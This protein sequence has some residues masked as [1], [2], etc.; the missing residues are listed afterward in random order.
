MPSSILLAIFLPSRP[1]FSNS[2]G[3]DEVRPLVTKFMNF[4][5]ALAFD[6][7]VS[8]PTNAFLVLIPEHEMRDDATSEQEH[9]QISQNDSVAWSIVRSISLS[10]DIAGNYAVQISPPVFVSAKIARS[11]TAYIPDDKAQGHATLIYTLYIVRAPRDC[12]CNTRV[13]AHGSQESSSI[14]DACG[15]GTK[16]H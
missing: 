6:P 10:I 4:R 9:D 16:Q 14:F 8:L 13:N 11:K 1:P 15:A 7:N 12:V 2:S 3:V 5:T